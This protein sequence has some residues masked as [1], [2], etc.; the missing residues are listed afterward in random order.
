MLKNIAVA[1]WGNIAFL[2]SRQHYE[3]KCTGK[4]LWAKVQILMKN[5]TQMLPI[6]MNEPSSRHL[7]EISCLEKAIFEELSEFG[8][9][10]CWKIK[11]MVTKRNFHRL[12]A[13]N[14]CCVLVPTIS[15]YYSIESWNLLFSRYRQHLSNV[16]SGSNRMRL[17][18]EDCI[19]NNSYLNYQY[20]FFDDDCVNAFD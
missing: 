12:E 15:L 1:P 5:F 17:I 7:E 18:Q 14:V 20:A 9:R 8:Q 6:L 2:Q 4:K 19:F 10:F 11:I 16:C 13:C 3:R